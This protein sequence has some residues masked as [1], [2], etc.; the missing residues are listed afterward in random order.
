[1]LDGVSK[2]RTIAVSISIFSSGIIYAAFSV[3]AVILNV[4]VVEVPSKT[5]IS[6]TLSAVV[7]E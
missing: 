2:L 4:F 5:F 3:C 7:N 1:M 6:A